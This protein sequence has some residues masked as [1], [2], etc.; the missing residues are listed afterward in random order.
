MR[1]RRRLEATDRPSVLS[2]KLVMGVLVEFKSHSSEFPRSCG[3]SE[4]P[5]V[6]VGSVLCK[7]MSNDKKLGRVVWK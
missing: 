4:S 1:G 6:T 5:W 7:I 3:S 2:E